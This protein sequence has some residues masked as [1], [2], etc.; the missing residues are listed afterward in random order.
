MDTRIKTP[1]MYRKGVVS[2]ASARMQNDDRSFV[3]WFAYIFAQ[4]CTFWHGEYSEDS[5]WFLHPK[6]AYPSSGTGTVSV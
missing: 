5:R 1:E 4:Y 6:P 3:D 2:E